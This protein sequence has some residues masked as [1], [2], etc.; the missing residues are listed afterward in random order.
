[1][2]KQHFEVVVINKSIR[3]GDKIDTHSGRRVGG[4]QPKTNR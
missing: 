4:R 1:V 3:K 2:R